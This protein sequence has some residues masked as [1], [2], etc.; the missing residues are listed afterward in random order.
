[1]GVARS[2]KT[3][4][5]AKGNSAKNFPVWVLHILVCMKSH[6]SGDGRAAFIL[7]VFYFVLFA[8]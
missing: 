5:Y 7:V 4:F 8:F 3:D 2:H 1:M 6:F